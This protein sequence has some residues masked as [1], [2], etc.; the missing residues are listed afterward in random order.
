MNIRTF[1]LVLL[2]QLLLWQ[3][4]AA[5]YYVASWGSNSHPGTLALPWLTIQHAVDQAVAGDSVLIRE[6]IYP[7]NL[8][9]SSSGNL[10]EGDIVFASFPGETAVIDGSLPGGTGL[11]LSDVSYVVLED[12]EI[13]NWSN[14]ALWIE[15]SHHFRLNRLKVH[16]CFFG[17]GVA[18]GSH[19]FE[20]NEVETYHFAW[21]GVDVSPSG[22]DPCYNGVFNHCVSRDC[23][24]STANSDGFALG[25]GNQHGFIFNHCV[26]HHM[27]DGFDISGRNTLLNECLAYQC[28]NGGYKLWQDSLVLTNCISHSNAVTN[29]ELDWHGA[30]KTVR[31]QNCTFFDAGVYN[32]QIYDP[33]DTLYMY[34]CIVAGGD[35]IGLLIDGY[36][37]TG[38]YHGDYNIFQNDNP[39]RTVN[40]GFT[41]EFS[42]AQV[43]AGAWTA[44]SGEDAHSLVLYTDLDSLFLNAMADDFHLSAGS[45]AIDAADSVFAP[46]LDFDGNPRP[47]GSADDIGAFEYTGASSGITGTVRYDNAVFSPLAAVKVRLLSQ[48]ACIDSTLTGPTGHFTFTDLDPAAYELQA[49]CSLPWGGVNAAD[50]LIILKHFVGITLLN[51]LKAEAADTDASAFINATDAL[52][53]AKRFT[54]LI[55][56]FPAGDWVSEHPQLSLQPGETLNLDIHCVCTGDADGSYLPG[57]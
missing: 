8:Y 40:V 54:G 57:E 15:Y 50:A 37:G 24:D 10:P 20:L 2:G 52:M 27:Y 6:G 5:T 47:L 36:T 21:Y 53:A 49:V 16:A 41:T 23:I 55:S 43:E 31:M 11:V 33:A 42:T 17:I 56:S 22:G 51:G 1:N 12:L 26:A 30:P 34:N 32:V 44:Y 3:A 18:L 45:I 14:A 25:H 29:V 13:R 46:P 9:F 4:D 48:G 39:M 19:D 7:E 38:N 35:N 28:A